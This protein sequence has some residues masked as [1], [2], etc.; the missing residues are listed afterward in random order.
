MIL[1]TGIPVTIPAT[2]APVTTLAAEHQF[3][4]LQPA[5]AAGEE[6]LELEQLR[7][8]L[9]IKISLNLGTPCWA[10]GGCHLGRVSRW[11]A[12]RAAPASLPVARKGGPRPDLLP[13]HGRPGGPAARTLNCRDPCEGLGAL[14]GARTRRPGPKP[15]GAAPGAPR[16]HL[17]HPTRNNRRRAIRSWPP[18]SV[19]CP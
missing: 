10:S 13:P 1:A 16:L 9:S 15:G 11:T 3:R 5:W 18:S 4:T 17:P 12:P 19:R 8:A 14:A 7:R 2:E 6:V